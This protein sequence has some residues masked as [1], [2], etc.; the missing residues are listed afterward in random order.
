MATPITVDDLPGLNC[1]LCGFRSC[2]EFVDQLATRPDLL[3]RCIHLSENRIAPTSPVALPT[4][5]RTAPSISACDTCTVST[6]VSSHT[7]ETT[8]RDTLGREFDFYLE[9]FP[10]E[11][12]PRGR[13]D[14]PATHVYVTMA[15]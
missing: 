15:A 13:T 6:C 11:P 10:E 9:H 1:G 4:E 3:Q 2:E 14:H 5:V 12:G 7:T 8:W